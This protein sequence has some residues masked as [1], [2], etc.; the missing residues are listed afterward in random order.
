MS[1]SYGTEW[2]SGADSASGATSATMATPG[3]TDSTGARGTSGNGDSASTADTVKREAAGVKDTAVEQAKDVASTA[4]DEASSVIG[5]VKWQAKDLYA[6]TQRELKDQ[7]NTQQQRVAAG[8]RSVG[9]DLQSMASDSQRQ[10][11]ASDLVRQVSG[12]LSSAASWLGD[13]DAGTVLTEVK[14]Y[15]RRKPGTFIL[16]AAITGV[17]VGRLTRALASNASDQSND[18]S[19]RVTSQPDAWAPANVAGSASTASLEETPIYAQTSPAWSDDSLREDV[20]GR[21]GTV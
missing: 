13:R 2:P 7:A 9:Q 6:Q 21:P 4:K 16:A 10:G 18:A 19:T 12:R 3:V 1:E 14:R 5:E 11:V 15:A 20:D 17:V 8:L